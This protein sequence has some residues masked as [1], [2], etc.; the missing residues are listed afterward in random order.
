MLIADN[1]LEGLRI[2]KSKSEDG[3]V[4]VAAEAGKDEEEVR[5]PAAGGARVEKSTADEP[6]ISYLSCAS[7]SVA[8]TISDTV[9]RA[10][11][12]RGEPAVITISII[13]AV[14]R[15]NSYACNSCHSE[16]LCFSKECDICTVGWRRD[17]VYTL[18][19][20]SVT[21]CISVRAV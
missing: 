1:T 20:G 14:C 10:A 15:D 18:F 13:C 2:E 17:L 4:E 16:G 6:G 12:L 9:Q 8:S 21:Q 19:W 3:A 7:L 5:E 11:H